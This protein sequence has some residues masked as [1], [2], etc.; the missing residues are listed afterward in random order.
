[1]VSLSNHVAM[2]LRFTHVGKPPL[3]R[4]RDCHPRIKYGVAMTDLSGYA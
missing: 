3:L 2:S 4:R 1:M